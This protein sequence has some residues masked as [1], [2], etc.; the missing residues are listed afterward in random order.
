[1]RVPGIT[2]GVWTGVFAAALLSTRVFACDSPFGISFCAE[3]SGVC[4]RADCCAVPPSAIQPGSQDGLRVSPAG[5]NLDSGRRLQACATIPPCP[6]GNALCDDPHMTGLS[7][8]SL[9]WSGDD[10]G[11]Y[12]LIRGEE[13]QINVRLTAP[14]AKDFPNRQL[15]TGVSVLSGNAHYFV[16]EVNDPYSVET[17][18]CPNGVRPCLADGALRI[19]VDG[20]E[21]IE[22]LGPVEDAQLHDGLTLSTSNLPLECWQFGGSSL[23]LTKYE[24]I[25]SRSR[26]L[27]AETFEEWVLKFAN[28][29]MAAPDWCAKFISEQAL[30]DVQSTHA[31]LKI[32]TPSVTVRINVG[33]NHQGGGEQDWDGRVLPDLDFWLMNMGLEGL[34]IGDPLSGILGETARPVLDHSGNPIMTGIEAIRG[35]VEEYRVSGALGVDFQLLNN[36]QGV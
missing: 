18:G 9:E 35:T 6:A 11:W 29:N 1:M 4:F 3:I 26:S 27:V 25:M 20:S 22:L 12:S 17:S 34:D 32:A 23:W 24:D 14:L 36:K 2:S 31:V 13:V 10:G 19:A 16:V 15:V 21:P 28:E 30:V 33:I 5:E 7:G 8:Q